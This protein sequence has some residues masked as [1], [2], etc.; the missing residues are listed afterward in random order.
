MQ[1]L[2]ARSERQTD[3]R[4]SCLWYRYVLAVFGSKHSIIIPINIDCLGFFLF[5]YVFPG[6]TLY[7]TRTHKCYGSVNNILDMHTGRCSKGLLFGTHLL[8]WTCTRIIRLFWY[9]STKRNKT[10]NSFPWLNALL[11]ASKKLIRLLPSADYLSPPK[12]WP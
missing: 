1:Q 8:K 12:G 5:Y 7:C 4:K 3:A 10:W 6:K 11:F 2:C 9:L